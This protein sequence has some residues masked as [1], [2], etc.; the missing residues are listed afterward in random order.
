MLNFITNTLQ[1]YENSY[2]TGMAK[3][4]PTGINN[5]TFIEK[6]GAFTHE[7]DAT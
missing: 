6:A 2:T 5:V 7:L 1:N 3:Y 4:F